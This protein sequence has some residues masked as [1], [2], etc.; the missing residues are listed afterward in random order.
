MP[1]T[2]PDANY[3]LNLCDAL[4]ER[5][6]FRQHHFPFLFDKGRS[7]PVDAYYPAVLSARLKPFIAAGPSALLGHRGVDPRPAPRL[8]HGLEAAPLRR[9]PLAHLPKP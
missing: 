1:R 2:D 3:V 9:D 4:L 7:L 8:R 6:S 5:P